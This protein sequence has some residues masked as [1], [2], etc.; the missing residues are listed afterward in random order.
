[1]P[2]SIADRVAARTVERD[3]CRIWTGFVDERGYPRMS[4]GSTV[5]GTRRMRRV[6]VV[7]WSE[8]FG[9]PPEGH[10]VHHGCEDKRCVRHLELV[11]HGAHSRLHDNA[12]KAREARRRKRELAGR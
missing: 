10:D 6:H 4:A 2:R 12:A 11:E 5:D 1:V 9:P 3:G 7:L 8:L